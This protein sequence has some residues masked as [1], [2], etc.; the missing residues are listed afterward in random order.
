MS[1]QSQESAPLMLTVSG[2]RGIV[3]KSLTPEVISRYTAAFARFLRD[4]MGSESLKIVLA[5]DGRAGGEEIARLTVSALSAHGVDV[6]DLG[7]ATTPTA[8]LMVGRHGADAG[9]VITASHNPA[10]WNGFKGIDRTGAAL[11][12]DKAARFIA[13]YHAGENQSGQ[14]AAA[15]DTQ[16]DQTA[17]HEH[18][19]RVLEAVGALRPLEQIK[20]AGFKVV[21]DSLNASGVRA[22]KLLCDAL[23]C[24]L[25]HIGDEDTG[26]FLHTPEPTRENLVGLCDAVRESGAVVG[27]AQDPDADRLAIVDGH[28]EYI[29]EEFTL[30]LCAKSVLGSMK[31]E[32][33]RGQTLV[34]NLSTSR[35]LEDVAEAFGAR[36][37]RSPV[38]E[39][40][41][42]RMMREHGA[43][44]AGE[45]NGGVIW[46]EVVSIRD[47]ISSI[48]LVLSLMAATGRSVS[49]LVAEIPSYAIVKRKTA[50]REGL[51]ERAL[52]AART[53]IEGAEVDSQDGVRL[54]FP[55][56]GGKAWLHVRESNTEPILRL[57]AEAPTQT[58]AE[59]ILDN[60]E[61][62]IT[63]S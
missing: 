7:V 44:I 24:E 51:A 38:G 5:R 36:V 33:A 15:A 23:G 32:N 6:I 20:D 61:R 46:P 3:G 28:G 16:H 27:F 62:A 22:V 54:D 57:I 29:G 30:A 49:Q 12:P 41:V 48:A 63:S 35:M 4:E 40:N 11:A 18:V 34:A 31:P 42:V 43:V 47:S 1:T 26:V 56:E 9:L 52:A 59:E 45:G 53:L 10:E 60:A 21:V 8:G 13:I 50:I 58:Q 2:C 39:A 37:L 19:S 25:V 14:S 55:V 17:A